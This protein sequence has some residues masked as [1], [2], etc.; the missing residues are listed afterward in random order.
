VAAAASGGQQHAGELLFGGLPSH[1]QQCASHTR[2][3]RPPVK[4][5]YWH[6]YIAKMIAADQQLKEG[7]QKALCGG[8]GSRLQR[9]APRRSCTST[10][11]TNS[12]SRSSS[13]LDYTATGRCCCE[14]VLQLVG[15]EGAPAA[16]RKKRQRRGAGA[17]ATAP[18]TA[19]GRAG[20]AGPHPGPG[21]QPKF[22]RR[23]FVCWPATWHVPGCC[24]E[25]SCRLWAGQACCC[26]SCLPHASSSSSSA[27]AAAVPIR[28]TWHCCCTRSPRRCCCCPA[29]A[30]AP[31]G[32]R[33]AVQDL[34]LVTCCPR[35]SLQCRTVQCWSP[36][37]VRPAR[38][39]ALPAGPQL[40]ALLDGC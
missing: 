23:C 11:H 5:C 27:S 16:A 19:G 9:P 3:V 32:P 15:R 24:N 8:R 14:A 18:A 26:Q 36:R 34:W 30:A 39:A 28:S 20:S 6:V 25:C 1:Q 29:V 7:Q 40:H 33:S 35:H 37:A 22:G 17:A 21:C 12:S 31:A 2:I 13:R 38:G 4:G 10:P